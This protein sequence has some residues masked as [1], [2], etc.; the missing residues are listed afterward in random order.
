MEIRKHKVNTKWIY[1]AYDFYIGD[2][3]VAQLRRP[4]IGLDYAYVFFFPKLY[5]K[6]DCTR[7][8]LRYITDENEPLETAIKIVKKKLYKMASNTLSSITET[9]I[10]K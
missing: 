3:L 7:I 10:E 9:K 6:S 4:L 2:F 5:G 1:G 8:D